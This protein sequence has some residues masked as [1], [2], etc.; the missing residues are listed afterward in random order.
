MNPSR[1]GVVTVPIHPAGIPPLEHLMEVLYAIFP[2]DLS[3]VTGND[4]Y[5][6]FK[7]DARFHV[8][9]WVYRPAGNS[10][11]RRSIRYLQTQLLITWFLVR[12]RNT[13][14]LWIFF[15]GGYRLHLPVLAAK[16]LGKT[17]VLL[18]PGAGW[19]SHEESRDVRLNLFRRYLNYPYAAA[20]NLIVYSPTLIESWGLEEFRG[21]TLIGHEHFIDTTRFCQT[22]LNKDRPPAIAFI[23]RFSEEKGIQNFLDAIPGILADQENLQVL[24]AGDGPL[25]E[26]IEQKIRGIPRNDCIH[27]QPWI[28]HQ[29][30]PQYLNHIRLLVVPSY[31]EGLPNIVLEAMACGTPVLATPVGAIPD[32]FLDGKTGFLMEDNTPA[33]IIK[34]VLSALSSPDRDQIAQNGMIFVQKNYSFEA[35]L[36]RWKDLVDQIR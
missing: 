18:L 26:C 28:S 21:K 20:D 30:L 34:N 33:C 24:I 11:V 8:D 5:P 19:R 3:L 4:G 6:Y 36:H 23:G 29:D 31:T 32:I 10:V 7:Q 22:V 25:K 15:F 12:R 9:G 17:V 2:E 1:I 35:T 14:N 16:A 27:L 13:T